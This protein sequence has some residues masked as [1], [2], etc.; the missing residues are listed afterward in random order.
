MN[1]P[2]QPECRGLTRPVSLSLRN[3]FYATADGIQSL[4][5]AIQTLNDPELEVELK[6]LE[7]ALEHMRKRMNERYNWD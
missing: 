6:L 3:P 2:K 1:D 4:S 5:D 7:S